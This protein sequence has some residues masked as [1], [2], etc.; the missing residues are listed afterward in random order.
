MSTP[1]PITPSTPEA[2]CYTTTPTRLRIWSDGGEWFLDGAD[3]RGAFTEG[4]WSYDTHAAAVAALAEFVDARRLDGV[5]WQW[6][7]RRPTAA[8]R[9][10][11]HA[12]TGAA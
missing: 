11:Q 7:T 3:D 6:R 12:L 4:C 10:R 8:D 9:A 1:E 2:D 5:T